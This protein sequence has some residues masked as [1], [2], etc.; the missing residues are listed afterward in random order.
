MTGSTSGTTAC[1]CALMHLRQACQ[2]HSCH[3]CC[4]WGPVWTNIDCWFIKIKAACTFVLLLNNLCLL[5]L[6]V[7]A[8]GTAQLGPHV[9][10]LSLQATT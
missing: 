10:D 6:L 3:A 2:L 5:K 8:A 4:M 1:W 9:R 7:N